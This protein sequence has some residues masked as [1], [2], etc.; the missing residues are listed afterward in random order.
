MSVELGDSIVISL[1]FNLSLGALA[2]TRLS[3]QTEPITKE[4]VQEEGERFCKRKVLE[5]A[6]FER[7][8]TIVIVPGYHE[9]DCM[10][11]DHHNY[12]KAAFRICTLLSG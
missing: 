5:P 1:R 11:T 8:S 10:C 12:D 7:A 2:A 3:Y 9:S 6:T 4:W